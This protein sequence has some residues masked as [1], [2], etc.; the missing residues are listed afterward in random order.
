MPNTWTTIFSY[1]TFTIVLITS[2]YDEPTYVRITKS[3]EQIFSGKIQ[4]RYDEYETKKDVK[5]AIDAF[6]KTSKF[7]LN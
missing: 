2:P 1:R 6:I 5:T 3:N 4:R 7:T